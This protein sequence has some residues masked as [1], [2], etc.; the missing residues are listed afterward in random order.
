MTQSPGPN[1]S[2][3]PRVKFGALPYLHIPAPWTIGPWTIWPNSPNEWNKR[4]GAD[5]TPFMS[6][7]KDRN[8]SPVGSRGSILTRSPDS[9]PERHEFFN[10]VYAYSTIAWFSGAPGSDCWL[11]EVWDVPKNFTTKESFR[12]SGKFSWNMTNVQNEKIFPGPYMFSNSLQLPSNFPD[13]YIS[14]AKSELS[15]DPA[16]SLI[17]SFGQFH[18]VRLEAPY[19]SSPGGDIETLWTAYESMYLRDKLVT[20]P[21][22]GRMKRVIRLIKRLCQVFYPSR[23]PKRGERLATEIKK[24]LVKLEC[25]DQG[26]LSLIDDFCCVLWDARNK[27]SH[28]G[29]TNPPARIEVLETSATAL[30]IELAE[31]L[32]RLRVHVAEGDSFSMVPS[33]VGRINEI[34]LRLKNARSVVSELSTL[35]D[36]ELFPALQASALPKLEALKKLLFAFVGFKRVDGFLD[37]KDVEKARGVLRRILNKWISALLIS[38]PPN[39]DLSTIAGFPAHDATTLKSLKAAGITGRELNERLD[40]E[41]IDHLINAGACDLNALDPE[42]KVNMGGIPISLWVHA[43]VRLHEMAVG[44]ALK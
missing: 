38:A 22:P 27:H 21:Q 33:V 39:V 31:Q 11:L 20:P 24:E 35:S 40:S 10:A 2:A 18:E 37:N 12:R 5:L 1:S 8:G 19:Y 13:D 25:F 34:L 14:F 17:Q 23:Y 16:E 9:Q 32:I 43:Y 4:V 41:I 29:E 15:K 26:A 28:S 6:M 30:G 42:G 3:A 7:Y 44:Y 36:S